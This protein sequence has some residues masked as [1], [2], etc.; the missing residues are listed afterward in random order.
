MKK[1]SILLFCAL[2]CASALAHDMHDHAAITGEE[3]GKVHFPV[4]CA[5]AEA[6]PFERGVALLHSFWYE[7]AGKQFEAIAKQDPHCAMA[8]WGIAMSSWHQLWNHPGDD[9]IKA[10][11]EQVIK[12]EALHAKTARERAYILAMHEFYA[13]EKADYQARA[14]GYSAQMEKVHQQYSDDKEAAAFYALSLLASEPEG[15]TTFSNRKKA[16]AVLEPLFASETDHPGVAHYLIH[17]YDKPQLAEQGLTAARR[18]AKIAPASAHAVHMPSHIFARLGLW[19]DDINSNLSSIAITR[20]ASGMHM[21]GAGHQF[22]AMD[23]L[24]YA[25]LQT[26]R[27]ADAQKVIDEVSSMPKMEDSADVGYDVSSY[28]KAEFPAVYDLEMHHFADAAALQP[29][30]G[31]NNDTNA[32]TYYARALGAARSGKIQQAHEDVAKL[33]SFEQQASSEKKVG[34]ADSIAEDRKAAQAWIDHA[35]GNDTAA[36]ASLRQ[37]AEKAEAAGDEPGSLPAR[38]MLA[39]MLMEMKRPEQ[40]LAEYQTDLKFNPNRFGGL[41]GAARAAELAGKTD[42]ANAYYA[43]LVEVCSGSSSDRPELQHAR[44]LLAKE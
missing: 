44:E 37:V 21:G 43:Q 23:F 19:Q 31:A 12:A 33:Q 5:T 10:G 15:D 38:E 34:L 17:A 11:R 41:S 18:Y 35:E 24:V 20:K 32:I 14:N 4:S 39:D 26:G 1:W 9:T 28:A 25:Y 6:K 7:E 3:L 36:L 13:P 16:A 2:G 29:V 8:H 42:Q 40:A 27:E 30:P 22:H